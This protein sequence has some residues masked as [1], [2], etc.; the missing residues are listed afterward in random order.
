GFGAVI[1]LGYHTTFDGYYKSVFSGRMYWLRRFRDG[2]GG[3][4]KDALQAG[5]KF[6]DTMSAPVLQSPFVRKSRL[7]RKPR[8]WELHP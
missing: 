4:R 6:A 1:Y 8:P 5:K 2:A 7:A 3:N